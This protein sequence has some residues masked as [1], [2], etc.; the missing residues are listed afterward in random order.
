MA[1]AEAVR[2]RSRFPI[3]HALLAPTILFYLLQL[4][5]SGL[6]DTLFLSGRQPAA[7]RLQQTSRK[8]QPLESPQTLWKSAKPEG[9]KVTY[10]KKGEKYRGAIDPKLRKLL[11]S[12]EYEQMKDLFVRMLDKG[13]LDKF[14]LRSVEWLNEINLFYLAETEK[15]AGSKAFRNLMKNEFA[16]VW[17]TELQNEGPEAFTIMQNF[18]RRQEQYS[19]YDLIVIDIFPFMIRDDTGTSSPFGPGVSDNTKLEYILDKIDNATIIKQYNI[20]TEGDEDV[21]RISEKVASWCARMLNIVVYKVDRT[22]EI[23]LMP[24]WVD[25]LIGATPVLLLVVFGLSLGY[26]KMPGSPEEIKLESSAPTDFKTYV[27]KPAFS[28]PVAI[29][30]SGSSGYLV[31][32]RDAGADFGRAGSESR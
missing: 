9:L 16:K 17:P 1:D 27:P 23:E 24:G 10:L 5:A 12:E 8:A 22:T 3:L 30:G 28:P 26:V 32:P 20:L 11:E 18:Y 19:M 7:E 14:M 13:M 29:L 31:E 15:K 2:R 4:S 25:I 6:G 21:A